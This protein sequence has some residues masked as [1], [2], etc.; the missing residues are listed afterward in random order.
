MLNS[1]PTDDNLMTMRFLFLR[2]R[3]KK[4]GIIWRAREDS[5]LRPQD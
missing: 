4:P 5:N 3:T 2:L 1:I